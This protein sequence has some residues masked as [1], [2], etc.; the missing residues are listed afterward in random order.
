MSSFPFSEGNSPD[1]ERHP[2]IKSNFALTPIDD[3]NIEKFLNK[4]G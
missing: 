2:S 4:G 1:L 3:K